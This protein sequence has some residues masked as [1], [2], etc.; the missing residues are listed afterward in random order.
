MSHTTEDLRKL[1][2]K[3][4]EDK[5]QISFARI[6]EWYE[7]WDGKVYVSFSGG[8]DS[9]VLLDLVRSIYP[10]VPA[11]FFDTGLEFPELREFVLNT[12]NVRILKPKMSF[13]L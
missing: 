9:T 10:E 5:I 4:L 1:Q 12:P 3:S 13:L 8:K 6:V 11:V 7:H 2:A